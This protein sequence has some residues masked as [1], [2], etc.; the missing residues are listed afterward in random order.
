VRSADP[1]GS[2]LPSPTLTPRRRTAIVVVGFAIVAAL[3]IAVPATAKPVFGIVPQ[4]GAL[5]T[6]DDLDLMPNAGIGGLRTMMPWGQVEATR[7]EYD[8]SQTDA[9]VRETTKRGIAPLFFLYGTP[10]WAAKL[11]NRACAPE[12]C[13]IYPPRSRASLDAFEAF[14]AAAAARYGPGGKFWEAPATT[15]SAPVVDETPTEEPD[16]Y[17]LDLCELFPLLPE[18]EIPQPPPTPPPPTPTPP[19]PGPN[20]PPCDCTEAHPI[21]AWQIWNEQNSSKYFG[22]KVNV[23]RYAAILKSAADGIR[24]VDPSAEIV[25]GGMWGPNSARKVVT[26]TKSYL[27]RLY[28]IG[29]EDSF[30]AIALHPYANNAKGSVDQLES[31][32]RIV[33]KAGDPKVGVWITE[34]GWAGRG[35]KHNPYV[36]G[37]AGQARVLTRALSEFK[38]KS[39]RFN[40]RAVFWYSWRDKKGGDLICEWCGHAGLRT[41]KGAE[42]PAWRAF[43]RVARS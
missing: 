29:A 21:T 20:E 27:Q 15:A 24:G 11:D 8:W 1:D 38:R 37:L 3:A 16:Q 10:E 34:I 30:D 43:V 28:A 33:T 42:K 6:G 40:L 32:R 26:T 19:P 2:S 23:R 22:P 36:K 18:C 14:A 39:R 7:G 25:L 35:P 12:T 31:V 41:K 4:D 5:P 9:V 13:S 17:L